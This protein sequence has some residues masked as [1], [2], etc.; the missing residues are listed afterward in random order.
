[1]AGI[2]HLYA[3]SQRIDLRGGVFDVRIGGL[4]ETQAGAVL[5]AVVLHNRVDMTHDVTYVEWPPFLEPDPARP[6]VWSPLLRT[7]ENRDVTR[8]WG[9]HVRAARPL[10]SEGWRGGLTATANKR[11]HPKIPNYEIQNIPRD[12]GSSL[13]FNLGA[14]LVREFGAVTFGVEALLEPIWADTWQEAEAD[15]L[16]SGGQTIARGEK[17]LLN[18]FRF[19]N[20]LLRTGAEVNHGG[21]NAQLG[22][23]AY[24]IRYDL[25]QVDRL[26]GTV[27]D[28]REDWIEWTPTWSAA[29]RFEQATLRYFGQALTGTGRPG[30]A[31]NWVF[32]G[33]PMATAEG[34]SGALSILT[35]PSGPLTLQTATVWTH[36]LAVVVPIR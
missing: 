33:V 19:V 22:L 1:M 20:V 7:D 2:E 13:A 31:Q 26:Q 30:V 6:Q 32:D 35:A 11:S 9:A 5:E 8:T 10:G 29:Y 25:E 24:S 16:A 4:W 15:T 27:R 17:T 12:P 34:D 28:Q 23:Q 3:G 21:F 36:Q 18:D 14:G